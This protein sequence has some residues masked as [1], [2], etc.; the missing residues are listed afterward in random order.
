MNFLIIDNEQKTQRFAKRQIEL[1]PAQGLDKIQFNNRSSLLYDQPFDSSCL[2]SQRP[3]QENLALGRKSH[4]NQNQLQPA[5]CQGLV[6]TLPNLLPFDEERYENQN[7]IL[8]PHYLN[9]ASLPFIQHFFS[10]Q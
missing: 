10:C 7:E 6:E 4:C 9:S 5:N 8:D 2:M 1:L 3:F